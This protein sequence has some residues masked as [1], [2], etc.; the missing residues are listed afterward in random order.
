MML[1]RILA[2]EEGKKGKEEER[3]KREKRESEALVVRVVVS[4]EKGESEALVVKEAFS[5]E[6]LGAQ[7]T[8]RFAPAN[9]APVT[10]VQVMLEREG[11]RGMLGMRVRNWAPKLHSK[12]KK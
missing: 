3:E 5:S 12:N 2:K 6:R 7:N 11:S 10:P 9:H 4:G 8:P 1:V